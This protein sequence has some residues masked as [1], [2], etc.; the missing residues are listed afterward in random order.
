MWDGSRYIIRGYKS[1]YGHRKNGYGNQS[2]A[3]VVEAVLS[4]THSKG[5]GCLT[6]CEAAVEHHAVEARNEVDIKPAQRILLCLAATKI[7][8]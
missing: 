5:E 7:Q 2:G 6:K 4:A 1:G 8:Q 3:E